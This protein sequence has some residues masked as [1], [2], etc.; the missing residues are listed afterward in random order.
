[1]R[2]PTGISGKMVPRLFQTVT[3][4]ILHGQGDPCNSRSPNKKVEEKAKRQMGIYKIWPE[5]LPGIFTPLPDIW[6]TSELYILQTHSDGQEWFW[7]SPKNT[8]GRGKRASGI[9]LPV[10]RLLKEPPVSW[11][12]EAYI[13][14]EAPNRALGSPEADPRGSLNKVLY[15]LLPL[16][17]ALPEISQLWNLCEWFSWKTFNPGHTLCLV[18]CNYS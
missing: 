6:D 13:S 3:A 5:S 9:T 7:D 4:H 11:L 18:I 15:C 2:K 14:K 10:P 17:R 12:S 8:L 1:M 16:R